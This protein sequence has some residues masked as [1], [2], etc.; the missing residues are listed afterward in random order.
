MNHWEIKQSWFGHL[1][2]L[3]AKRK[4]KNKLAKKTKKI[5]RSK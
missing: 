4:T 1:A 2:K 5:Q 3:T